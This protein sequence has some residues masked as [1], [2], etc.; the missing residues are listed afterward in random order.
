M[1][2][3]MATRFSLGLVAVAVLVARPSG[4]QSDALSGA[5]M[6]LGGDAALA[7]ITSIHASGK[8]TMAP[9]T[10]AGHLDVYLEFPDKFARITRMPQDPPQS[11]SRGRLTGNQDPEMGFEIAERKV[12]DLNVD[13]S[14][15][16]T[17]YGFNGPTMLSPGHGVSP[18][19]SQLGGG[20]R[21]YARFAIP[22]LTKTVAPYG[23]HPT[24]G[25]DAVRYVGD[26]GL[27]WSLVLDAATH[28]PSAL[29]WSHSEA[30]WI[31]TFSDFRRVGT[32]TWPHRMVTTR[33][34]RPVEDIR[35]SKYEI[36][37]KISPKV[38]K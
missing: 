26:D 20:P 14:V 6:A 33:A 23:T 4:A 15:T 9:R 25:N 36:N 11:A 22:L 21:Q 8:I 5:R 38:F 18:Y 34:G 32:V 13:L 29:K 28:R 3:M 24:S 10:S 30:D 7:R 17:R 12:P 1:D 37:P 19:E 31:T 35:I 2:A 16:T 27:T